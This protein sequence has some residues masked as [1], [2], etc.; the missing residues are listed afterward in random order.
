[1]FKSFSSV[2]DVYWV[3][4]VKDKSAKTFD[5]LWYQNASDALDTLQ[6]Q[7]YLDRFPLDGYVYISIK[8]DPS[9][10]TLLLI[11]QSQVSS[12]LT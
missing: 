11:R 10:M 9:G 2:T 4:G 8:Q 5:P 7:E 1:M 3:L 6:T 12:G